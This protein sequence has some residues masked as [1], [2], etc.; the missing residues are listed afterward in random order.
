MSSDLMRLAGINSGYDSEAMIE[1]LMSAYQTKIDNQ[2]RKLTKLQ[3]QQEAYRSI[4]SKLTTFK[5]KYFD[6]LKRDTYLMSPN[7][8]SKFKATVTDKNSVEGKSPIKVT[9]TNKSKVGSHDLTVKQTATRA[10]L[11]GS[12]VQP[13]GFSLDIEKA[14]ESNY[15]TD[16]NTR[17]Y[18]FALDV[19]VGDVTKTVE[20]KFDVNE[21]DGEID[22]DQFAS[23]LSDSLN[24][25]LGNLFGTTGRTGA[26]VTG[27]VSGAGEE[28]FLQT[29][30]SADHKSLEFKV[31]GNAA[32][33]LTEKIGNFG[34]TSAANSQVINMQS[35]VTGTNT[36]SITRGD[37][38]RNVTFDGVSTTYFESRY[39]TGN[40]DVLAEYE[41][42]KEAAFR[43][44]YNLADDAEIDETAFKQF[45]Y[46]SA[47][48]AEDK[49]TESFLE[50]AN[51]TFADQ[52]IRFTI[53]DGSLHAWGGGSPLTFTITSVEGGTL[54][55]AKGS[56]TNRISENMT[57]KEMGVANDD[58]SFTIN[59]KTIEAKADMK[60]SDFIDAVNKSGAGV[61]MSYS[62]VENRFV[63]EAT[64]MGAGGNVN[65]EE[66]EFTKALGL[67]GSGVSIEAGKNA[68]FELDGV[69]IYHNSNSYEVD[70]TTI[71][72]ADAEKDV[73]YHIGISKDYDDVK[74]AIK[75]FVKDYNQLIDDIYG[76]IGT[77][78]ARDENN[79]TYEPLTT[80]EKD[81][82]SEKEIERYEEK[83]KQGVI[84][85][86]TTISSIMSQ[87]RTALYNSVT[88]EDGKK[89]GLYN[90]GIKTVSDFD[91][92]GKLEID[93]DK[94]DAAFEKDPDAIAKLFTDTDGIMSKVN[95]VI[96]NAVRT[97]GTVKGSLVRKAGIEGQTSAKDNEIYRQMEQIN[98]RISQLQE[99]YNQKEDY[100]WKVFTNLE[101]MMGEFNSQ[102]SYMASYLGSYGTSVQ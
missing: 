5:N 48:A 75:D 38:T 32:V 44:Q 46:T 58:F 33:S 95:K 53:S 101:K 15:T 34:L 63:L 73:S 21:T 14:A 74:Q 77:A 100:W 29:E 97:T 86:D 78:P 82:L 16:G 56:V 69:E 49:N 51:N 3:W 79:D 22:M 93:E 7:I 35:C 98:K 6:I 37:V 42:L 65:V 40:E 68:V 2:N 41:R 20:F 80:A 50:A 24:A 102:S 4:T 66:N 87:M 92:H 61:T 94:L 28:Y 60:V 25:Q 81:E 19:K 76:E 10:K 17:T 89:F 52:L 91:Q 72:F 27:A 11:K 43:K 36:V 23:G 99:R 64:D 13:V 85:N 18:D 8:F 31:G 62:K 26:D 67:A 70:G 71:D 39:E 1:Q 83:A 47:Q 30:L 45:K 88:L 54:G 84:Y 59:G 55:L 12:E 96:D 90:M 57:L 9:T